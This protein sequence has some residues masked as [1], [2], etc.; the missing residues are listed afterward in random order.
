MAKKEGILGGFD[1]G[2]MDSN[3]SDCLL[4]NVTEVKT[5]TDIDRFVSCLTAAL[6]K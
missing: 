6:E 1:L 3:L 2:R 4:V 5:E